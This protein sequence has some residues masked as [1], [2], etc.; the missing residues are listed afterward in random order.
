MF[1]LKIYYATFQCGC[2]Y[3]FKH[4]L[5]IIFANENMKKL[6]WKS[7]QPFLYCRPAQNQSKSY[8]LFHKN[9]SLGYFYIMT[10]AVLSWMIYLSVISS[11]FINKFVQKCQYYYTLLDQS[12]PLVTVTSVVSLLTEQR[13]I[14]DLHKLLIAPLHFQTFHWFCTITRPRYGKKGFTLPFSCMEYCTEMIW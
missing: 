14:N 1:F 10:K 4:F 12:I 11:K 5:N 2:Y 13:W 3:V 8:S 9:F 6:P 7:A